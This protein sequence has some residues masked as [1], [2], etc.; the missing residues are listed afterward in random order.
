MHMQRNAVDTQWAQTHE[1][2]EK[3]AGLSKQRHIFNYLQGHIVH[4]E[5]CMHATAEQ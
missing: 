5:A 2:A 1:S 3:L 4:T